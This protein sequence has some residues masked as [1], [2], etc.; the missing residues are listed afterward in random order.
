MGKFCQISTGSLPLIYVEVGFSAFHLKCL[1]VSGLC[2]LLLHKFSFLF[3]LTLHYYCSHIDMHL[4][5]CAHFM[6]LFLKN[7]VLEFR[8]FSISKCLDC[9]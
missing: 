6:I 4:L 9:V 2:N 3:I 5:F 7:A 8:H 1:G